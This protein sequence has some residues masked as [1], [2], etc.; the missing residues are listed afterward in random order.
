V[1]GYH[2]AATDGEIGHVDDYIID[3]ENWFVRYLVVETGGWLNERKVLLAPEWIESVDWHESLV[4]ANMTRQAI[5]DSPQYAPDVP[6]TR[7]YESQLFDSYHFPR[8]WEPVKSD[9]KQH[10]HAK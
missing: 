9:L 1:A 8:Y 7:E 3:S 2:I 10:E 6:L 4:H 5:A